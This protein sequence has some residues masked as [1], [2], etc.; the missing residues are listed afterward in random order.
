MRSFASLLLRSFAL[1]EVFQCPTAFRMT[2]SENF[3]IDPAMPFSPAAS[4]CC[5]DVFLAG[6]AWTQEGN[7]RDLIVSMSK[8]RRF[9]DSAPLICRF[10]KIGQ[11]LLMKVSVFE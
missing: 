6:V 4:R 2:A 11:G 3:R 7:E 5:E 8:R 9:S 1:F 10:T